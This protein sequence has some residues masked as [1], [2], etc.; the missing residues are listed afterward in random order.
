MAKINYEKMDTKIKFH[1]CGGY[2]YPNGCPFNGEYHKKSLDCQ[3]CIQDMDDA[4]N[5][6]EKENIMHEQDKKLQ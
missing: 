3:E 4:I 5:E 1:G 2:K 6:L